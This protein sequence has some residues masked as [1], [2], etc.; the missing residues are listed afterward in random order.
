MMDTL[1]WYV[2]ISWDYV[3]QMLPCMVLAAMVF[4]ALRPWRKRRLARR[5][6]ASGVWRETV[7]L[8]FVMFGAGLAALTVFP[9]NF[10]TLYHWQEAF[11]GREAF[12]PLT[13]LSQSAQYIGWR[14][15]FLWS[16]QTM[17]SWTFYMAMAN[18][19]IFLPVGFFPNLLWRPWWW[20]GLLTGFCVSFSIEF[21]QLFVNRST[22]V[23][24]LILNT[25]GAFAGGLTA[26]LLRRLAPR[27][28]QHFQVEV[29]HGR[30]TGDRGPA[31]EA[32]AGQL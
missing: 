21:L 32:G 22:D 11:Q 5:G 3:A 30:E 1:L 23:D 4:F 12:F 28:T 7:L 31:P 26:L 8:L 13:P 27:F 20:K 17:G 16:F 19:L 10:W 25:L 9:A 14:P 2:A 15:Y 24:D 6:L 18:A 29:Q